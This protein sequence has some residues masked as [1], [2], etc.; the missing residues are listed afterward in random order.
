[1][2]LLETFFNAQVMASALPALMRGLVNTLLL[3]LCAIGIGIPLGLVISLVRLY[4]PKPFRWLT[5]GYI[6]IFRAMPVLV[7]LILIYYALPFVGIRLSSWASATLAFSFVMSA[8]SAEVF[9]SGIESIPKGQF[10]AAHALGLPFILTLRKVI[11][12]QAV[13]LVIPPTTSNCVSMFKDT[14]LASAVALP[15]LL[16]EAND[17]Q[18]FYANP[19]PLIAAAVVYLAFLWPMVRLVGWV[20]KR[21]KA[22]ER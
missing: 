13:R 15:E 22:A 20:E 9:R 6:D 4:A 2:T 21:A 3:G 7:V 17:A 19:S 12:P 8:Y 1:M 10:E 16:K 11:L 5:I 18:A 14:S